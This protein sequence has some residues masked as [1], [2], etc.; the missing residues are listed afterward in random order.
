MWDFVANE[1]IPDAV[2]VDVFAGGREVKVPLNYEPEAIAPQWEE[3]KYLLLL[4][5]LREMRENYNKKE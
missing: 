2:A 3:G 5:V 1:L 4:Q